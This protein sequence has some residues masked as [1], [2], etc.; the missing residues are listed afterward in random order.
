MFQVPEYP[1]RSK[2]IQRGIS[3][4]KDLNNELEQLA[5]DH[6]LTFSELV[7]RCCAYALENMGD[8]KSTTE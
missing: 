7:E 3:L 5:E 1:R 6:N 8:T 2:R 4:A